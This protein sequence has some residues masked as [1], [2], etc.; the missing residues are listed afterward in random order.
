MTP[1]FPFYTAIYTA[2][3]GDPVLDVDE[4]D[5]AERKPGACD[6]RQ[7]QRER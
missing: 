7:L 2:V 1:V 4:A 3:L 5:G 6:Q